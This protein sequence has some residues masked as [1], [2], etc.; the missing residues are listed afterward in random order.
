M[1]SILL[2][3]F[4]AGPRRIS[5]IAGMYSALDRAQ[6]AARPCTIGI[7]ALLVLMAVGC[8][9][10]LN[11]RDVRPAD[12]SVTLQFPCRPDRVE[13]TIPLAGSPVTLQLLRCDAGGL[14]WAF[15]QAEVVG[16]ARVAPALQALRQAALA[17]VGAGKVEAFSQRVAG[18]AAGAGVQGM[19]FEGHLPGG[20]AVQVRAVVFAAG[21]R[22]HQATVFGKTVPAVNAALFFDSLRVGR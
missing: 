16:G 15:A 1:G 22:V 5:I 7:A 17:N 9:P 3:A 13:R 12:G 10:A 11:W 6:G 19:A 4:A 8:S 21:T 20:E 14:T 18:S 2:Q